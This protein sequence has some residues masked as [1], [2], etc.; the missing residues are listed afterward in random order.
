MAKR[1]VV[2]ALL[3]LFVGASVALALL[4]LRPARAAPAASVAGVSRA[5][6]VVRAEGRVTT[7]PGGQVTISAELA[8]TVAGVLAREGQTVAAGDV[9]AELKR[10]DREATLREAW[11]HAAE[12]RAQLRF[13]S[14][15]VKQTKTLVASGAVPRR[16]L[17]R[18]L[19][20]RDVARARLG[21][22]GASVQ[23]LAL[24][25][26]KTKIASPISGVLISRTIDP[27]ETVS[28]GAELFVVA[29]LS[30]L[31]VEAEVDEF[32][33]LAVELGAPAAISVD[34]VTDRTWRGHVDEI[35]NAVVPRRLR[36]QDPVRPTDSRVLLV[37]VAIDEP[38]P[39]KLGQ[40]VNLSLSARPR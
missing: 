8:G 18:M 3:A 7:Y 27:G 25:V 32:D 39:L 14:K 30:K 21:A 9:L 17:D 40:R 37:K 10:G 28:T 34:G 22:A 6:S 26:K 36:P 20:E 19:E 15:E 2:V 4:R 33:A 12:A 23:E 1:L 31:R 29:D 16:E 13:L 35:P 11:G 5:P 38:L 24:S